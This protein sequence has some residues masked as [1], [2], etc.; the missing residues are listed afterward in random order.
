MIHDGKFRRFVTW[1]PSR[2]NVIAQSMQLI[3]GRTAQEYNQRKGK[4]GAFWKDRYHAAAIQADEH[5]I[6]VW[7]TLI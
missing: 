3:A 4:Q 2:R 7:F 1:H 5:C 6:V